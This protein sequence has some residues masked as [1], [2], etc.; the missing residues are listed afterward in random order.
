[1]ARKFRGRHIGPRAQDFSDALGLGSDDRSIAILDAD[2]VAPAA[3]QA[4]FELVTEK[5]RRIET[6]DERLSKLEA[7]SSKQ[8]VSNRTIRSLYEAKSRTS[9][10]GVSRSVKSGR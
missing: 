2:G 5:D 4:L 3:I 7:S 8:R 9:L 1:M 6:L 10:K